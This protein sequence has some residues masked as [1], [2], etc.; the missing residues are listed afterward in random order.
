MLLECRKAVEAF[1]TGCAD[2]SAVAG[3]EIFHFLTLHPQRSHLRTAI[4]LPGPPGDSVITSPPGK[5]GM[6]RNVLCMAMPRFIL[7]P[8][9]RHLGDI[10]ESI[11]STCKT[12][13]DGAY[14]FNIVSA[15]FCDLV[16]LAMLIH[17]WHH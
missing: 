8:H 2:A 6:P 1:V 12:A 17:L 3:F 7:P 14:L 5:S 15:V 16:Y 10:D 9:F 13:I 11:V 4:S